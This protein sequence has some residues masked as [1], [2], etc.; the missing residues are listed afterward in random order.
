MSTPPPRILFVIDALT[1]GG[2]QRSLV[3]LA[4]ATAAR[5][6]AVTILTFRSV[7]SLPPPLHLHSGITLHSLEV[8]LPSAPF[9]VKPLRL[10][11]LIKKLRRFIAQYTP[12]CI[13]SFLEEVNLVTLLALPPERQAMRVIV[14]ERSYPG[15]SFLKSYDLLGL[16]PLFGNALRR[17]LYPRADTV[18]TLT[19]RSADFLRAE[20]LSHSTVI[21]NPVSAPPPAPT[22]THDDHLIIAIGRLAPEKRFDVLIE[23]FELVAPHFP[24]WRLKIYGEGPLHS[25]LAQQITR[26]NAHERI[27]LA[28]PTDAPLMT[29]ASRPVFALSS[30]VEG[31]PVALSEAMASGCAVVA[32]DCLTGPRELI[33]HGE[34]GL[35]V[36]RRDPEA[37]AKALGALLSSELTRRQLGTNARRITERYPPAM[38]F[39]RWWAEMTAMPREKTR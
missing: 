6:A 7:T 19:E 31:F 18:V 14:S 12:T 2:A 10:Y 27:E 22:A 9:P 13:V 32:T 20:G 1:L 11:E 39:D 16:V 21:P 4:N 26:M 17:Y 25:R 5:G 15:M 38:I 8:P 35:L 36:P 28:G 34:S 29:L 3:A 37:L 30:D 23:A 33:T 24:S